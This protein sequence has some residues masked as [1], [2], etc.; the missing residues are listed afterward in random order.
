[1]VMIGETTPRVK[2]RV[3]KI[4]S[5]WVLFALSLAGT[6]ALSHKIELGSMSAAVFL[7]PGAS[8]EIFLYSERAEPT[9]LSVRAGEEV[10]FVVKDDSRHNIAE[11]RTERRDARLESGEIG[12]DESYSL[13]FHGSGDFS[14]YDRLH[15]DIRVTVTIR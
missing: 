13:V 14:F 5:L 4:S 6:Y 11:D 10:V 7:S 15:Q 9:S 1:M 12:R 2:S 3:L 8:H